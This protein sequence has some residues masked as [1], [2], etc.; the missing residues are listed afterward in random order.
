MIAA[1]AVVAAVEAEATATAASKSL[2]DCSMRTLT[3]SAV[4]AS[5]CRFSEDCQ[6][7]KDALS[8]ATSRTGSRTSAI[9][10]KGGG[11]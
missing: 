9:S 1:T 6:A 4:R 3:L 10:R 5:L 2:S 8:R 7:I 11:E